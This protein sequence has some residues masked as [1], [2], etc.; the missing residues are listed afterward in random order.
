LFI[1]L[2]V[3]KELFL[4]AN[5]V[6]FIVERFAL[7]T[8]EFQVLNFLYLFELGKRVPQKRRNEQQMSENRHITTE[9]TC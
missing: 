9:I 2:V 8:D 7:L 5:F 4:A 6:H 1:I 3:R